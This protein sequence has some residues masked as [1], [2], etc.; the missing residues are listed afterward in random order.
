MCR[1]SPVSGGRL[2]SDAMKPFYQSGKLCSKE[3]APQWDD[4][5][6]KDAITGPMKD[7]VLRVQAPSERPPCKKLKPCGN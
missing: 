3:Y 6:D 7:P 5:V 4:P 2:I 1:F